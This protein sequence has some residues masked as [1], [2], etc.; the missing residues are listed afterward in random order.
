MIR[1]LLICSLILISNIG[2]AQT[3]KEIFLEIPERVFRIT[4]GEKELLI[5]NFLE[6]RKGREFGVGKSN[7]HLSV[8]EPKNGYLL[9][10]G[11]YEGSM[12]MTFWNISDGGKLIGIVSS[13][14]GG[15]CAN[16]L[17]FYYRGSKGLSKLELNNFL[18]TIAL[19]DFFDTQLMKADGVDLELEKQEFYYYDLLYRLP[20]NGKNIIVTS[21]HDVNDNNMLKYEIT[22]QLI[23]EWDDGIFKKQ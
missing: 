14:C 19:N 8:Y 9:L 2:F 1:I 21:Q 7:H 5:K 23:L 22:S 3:I 10:T 18:P 11:D 17:T 4:K 20:L 13:S 15:I 16:D 6:G 12:T